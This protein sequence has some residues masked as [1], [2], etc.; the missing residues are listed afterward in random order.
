MN[1]DA[2]NR[3]GGNK[4][5]DNDNKTGGRPEKDNDEKAEKTIANEES[6]S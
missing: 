4:T 1:A 5:G 3:T 2:L 6:Q